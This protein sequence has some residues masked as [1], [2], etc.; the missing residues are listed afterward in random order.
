MKNGVVPSGHLYDVYDGQMWQKFLCYNGKPFLSEPGYL[1]LILNLDFFQPY[2]HLSYSLGAIYMSILNLPRESRFKQE[3]TSLVGL[4]P[5]PH[6]PS[7]DINTFLKPLVGD[8]IKLWNGVDMHGP[9]QKICGY[10]YQHGLILLRLLG[11]NP[12]SW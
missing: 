4:I 12:T 8:L 10:F 3:N 1:G 6:E 9:Q 7:R 2:E 5:G 11:V